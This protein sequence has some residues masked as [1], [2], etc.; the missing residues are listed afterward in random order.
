LDEEQLRPGVPWQ[1]LLEM[2]IK[3]IKSAAVFVGKGGIGPWQ[4]MEIDAYLR[5]FVLRKC[6]VIPVLLPNAPEK[7]ELP[8]FLKGMTWIDFHKQNTDSDP[9]QR[10]IWG[11]T[12]QHS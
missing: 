2:Q 10:L 1:P 5:E 8:I 11:I 9:L 7:P 3:K 12:G 6:P 4:Q